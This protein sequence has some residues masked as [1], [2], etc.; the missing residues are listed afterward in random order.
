MIASHDDRP[1]DDEAV[2]FRQF[3]QGSQACK[4]PDM[5]YLGMISPSAL[6]RKSVIRAIAITDQA[7][8]L[9]AC[10]NPSGESICAEP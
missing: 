4:R 6:G 1:Q 2:G 9:T 7:I 8:Y 10:S 3:Q 5:N